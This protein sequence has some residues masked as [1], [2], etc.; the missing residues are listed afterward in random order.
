MKFGRLKD[1]THCRKGHDLNGLA[2]NGLPN[3]GERASFGDT[4]NYQCRS[5]TLEANALNKAGKGQR[6][7]VPANRQV[8]PRQNYLRRQTFERDQGVCQVRMTCNGDYASLDEGH[9]DHVYPHKRGGPYVM[10]NLQWACIQCNLVKNDMVTYKAIELV[11]LHGYV[12]EEG[13]NL[14]PPAS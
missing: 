12:H 6:P 10:W 1:A 7:R 14:M 5:C 13:F 9:E 3:R 2:S 8:R 4:T 11:Q